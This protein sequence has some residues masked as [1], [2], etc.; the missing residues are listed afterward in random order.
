ME[1]GERDR[2]VTI[3]QLTESIGESGFPVETW[4]S[5]CGAW[6]RKVDIIARE[7]FTRTDQLAAQ[8]QTVWELN[9]RPDMDP[10]LIDVPKKRRLVYQSRIYDI[11]V[12]SMIGMKEGVE[13]QTIAKVG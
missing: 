11:T 2:F 13:V 3:Q 1:A 5:L 9:Y 6:A 12:A 10:D 4:T 8:Q 7:R